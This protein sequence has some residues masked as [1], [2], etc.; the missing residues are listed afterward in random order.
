[1]RKKITLRKK[2]SSQKQVLV[3]EKSFC[4]SFG[5]RNTFLSLKNVSVTEKS[6]CHRKK[7][8]SQNFFLH[9]RKSVWP[10]T[11][12]YVREKIFRHRSKFLSSQKK[13]SVTETNFCHTKKLLYCMGTFFPCFFHTA[14]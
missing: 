9:H 6:F 3:T 12:I 8:P 14:V 4:L 5:Q 11:K 2:I 1:M 13:V 7:F 10:L